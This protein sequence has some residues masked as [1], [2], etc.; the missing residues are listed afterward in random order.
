MGRDWRFLIINGSN[1][2]AWSEKPRNP[3]E[4]EISKFFE[5]RDKFF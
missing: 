4:K 3:I 5:E 1:V 2:F